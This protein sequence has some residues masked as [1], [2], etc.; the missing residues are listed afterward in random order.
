MKILSDR[1]AQMF[2][3]TQLDLFGKPKESLSE[4]IQ[5]ISNPALKQKYQSLENRYKEIKDQID[6]VNVAASSFQDYLEK[7]KKS[8][9]L[10]KREVLQ[11]MTPRSRSYFRNKQNL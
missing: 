8:S 6:N 4:Q 9:A 2:K 10:V 5:G 11:D 1:L 3:K 7:V